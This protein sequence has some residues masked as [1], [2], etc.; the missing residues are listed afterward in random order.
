VNEASGLATVFMANRE[1]LHRFLRVRLRGTGDPED[2][3]H[4]LWVKLQCVETGPVTEPLAYLY[5][6]AENLLFDRRRS[7]LRRVNRETEWTK[8][9]I[10]GT[11]AMALD[12]VPNAERILLARDHLRRVDDVLDKLPE[13][14]AYAFR[15]VRI[16]GLPQKQIAISMGISVSAVEKHL[17]KA[18]RAVLEIQ[19]KM[20]AENDM[21]ERLGMGGRGHGSR[22]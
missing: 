6:M 22:E 17:Q 19:Q 5:R 18:Y 16:D 2:I 4:D 7:A 3:L 20:D 10:D 9:H 12:S 14:T 21:S 8:G 1:A 13:R 11:I 15:C